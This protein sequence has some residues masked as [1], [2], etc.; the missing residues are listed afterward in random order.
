M[1]DEVEQCTFRADMIVKT[2]GGGYQRIAD[3]R[4]M[5]DNGHT[6]SEYPADRDHEF[7]AANTHTFGAHWEKG[8]W[9][10]RR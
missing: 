5:G 8:R 2:S 7:Y 1:S 3:V 10:T 4:C 6:L 9:V